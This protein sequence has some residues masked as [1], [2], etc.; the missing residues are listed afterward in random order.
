NYRIMGDRALLVEL[1]DEIHP[2]VNRRVRELFITLDQHPI[3]G[4]MD[5]VPTY[6]SLLIIYDPLIVRLAVLKG[7]LEELKQVMNQAQIPEAKTLEIPVCYG[8]EYGPDLEWV[9]AYHDITPDEV[10]RVHTGTTYLV[11]M[12]GFT[13]GHP[14]I[15]ELPKSLVTP[16]RETPRANVPR[17]SVG[18]GMNQT[19]I[20][21][22]ES[23]GGMQIIGRTPWELFTP[24]R[25]PPTLLDMGDQV[26]FFP[27]E[28]EAW[29]HW[30]QERPW[31]S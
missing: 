7:K 8:G 22:V 21:P 16:R 28:Q 10:I 26:K 23:P 11:Y 14:Y 2:V 6:R 15:A 18:I 9:A 31:K 12:I 5:V 20:Y 25:W 1:G 29:V 3:Q 27:I 24:K 13:P 19:V 17:G 4:V 30:A